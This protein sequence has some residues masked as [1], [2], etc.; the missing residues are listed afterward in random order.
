MRILN[1]DRLR[2]LH[3][4]AISSGLLQDREALLAGVDEHFIAAL[5][6]AATPSGQLWRDLVEMNRTDIL[7]NGTLPLAIWLANV[8]LIAGS[9]SES[10]FFERALLDC[11]HWAPAAPHSPQRTSPRRMAYSVP[12]EAQ[13]SAQAYSSTKRGNS[14]HLNIEIRAG[15]W[16][17]SASIGT[18][19]GVVLAFGGMTAAVILVVSVLVIVVVIGRSPGAIQGVRPRKPVG[20]ASNATAASSAKLVA[21]LAPASVSVFVAGSVALTLAGINDSRDSNSDLGTPSDLVFGR[22]EFIHALVCD[23]ADKNSYGCSESDAPPPSNEDSLLE[24]EVKDAGVSLGR[25]GTGRRVTPPRVEM[26]TTN[27]S[28]RLPPGAIHR[29]VTQ[30]AGRFRLCFE[31]GLRNNPNL[32]GLMRVRFVIDRDGA[33][34][35]VG[36]SGSDMPDSGVVSCVVR[37]FYGL[38]FPRPEGGIVTVVVPITFRPGHG[39]ASSPVEARLNRDGDVA[40]E[41]HDA[42]TWHGKPDIEVGEDAGLQHLPRIPHRAGGLL[43]GPGKPTSTIV[44]PDRLPD[45]DAGPL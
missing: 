16:F 20:L 14:S 28:G 40:L 27:V 29:L 2:E 43:L 39:T 6:T 23:S 30:N 9:R 21:V 19:A 4:A 35:N 7:D 41:F 24:A 38:S 12:W 18:L 45:A 17:L 26:R 8:L 22:P 34:S 32:E 36:N 44:L 11:E 33:V 5:P 3:A 13:A 42:G 31:N 1:Y 10:A 15:S 37:S 25:A